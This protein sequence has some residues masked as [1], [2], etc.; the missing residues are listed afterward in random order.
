[1]GAYL[2][3]LTSTYSWSDA[4][5]G[6]SE[7]HH[8]VVVSILFIGIGLFALPATLLFIIMFTRS[9]WPLWT[10]TVATL[11]IWWN[12]HKT[13]YWTLHESAGAKMQERIDTMNKE[14]AKELEDERTKKEA[15]EA[16]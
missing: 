12:T 2:G 9:E 7:F 13:I 5:A 14:A 16:K 15:R 11:L 6:I 10:V 4:F 3:G 8:L 1:M